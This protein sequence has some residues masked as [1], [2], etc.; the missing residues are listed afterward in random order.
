[1]LDQ[2]IDT[3]T[4]DSQIAN[5]EQSS[6]RQIFKA[7]SLFGG[8]QV[9]Q[10]LIGIVRTKFVA[11][12]LGTT[13]VG[14][15][16][17]FNAPLQLILSVTGL[18]IT[19]SAVRDISEAYSSSDLT[20]IGVTVTT[21]R[22]WSLFAGILGLVVTALM[23]PLLSEWTFGNRDYTW[24]FVWLSFTLLLQT[25]SNGQKS[26]LQA[27]RRLKDLARSGVW[28][29]LLGLLTSVPLFYLFGVKGIVPSLIITAVT[30][31]LLSWH[32]SRKVETQTVTMTFRETIESGKS[33][34]KLGLVITVTGVIGFLTVYILNTF[35]NRTGGVDQVGLYNAGWNVIGQS[36]GLVFAAMTTDYFPRLAA[37]N[38][39][40]SI[41]NKLVNHQ[42]EMVTLILTP[43]LVA[44]IVAMPLLIRILYTSSFLPVV[45]FASWLLLGILFKGFVWPVGFIFPAKG[46]LKTFG[47]IEISALLFNIFSN[48]LGYHFL[49]LNGLGISFIIN[50]TF[51]LIITFSFAYKKYGFKYNISTIKGLIIS[52]ILVSGA[53][54]F[55]FFLEGIWRYFVGSLF[56][57]ITIFYTYQEL[58]KRLGLK[59]LIVGVRAKFHRK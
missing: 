25:V 57:A 13:G 37:I 46:D 22:R 59:S 54:S 10:I 2:D 9:F 40:D 55:S 51:G 36:T 11:V 20:R 24:A 32:F 23:A 45:N 42:A 50:Y 35:I 15:M 33:M 28:G 49:G 47:I 34:V 7:T 44:L 38:K 27:T 1:M 58:N 19:F 52:L 12:L 18:G 16:G 26:L 21:L 30:S 41:V 5:P 17:L 53:F 56:F 4:S 48:V 14:I 3:N 6:Y 43:I 8:V 31:L 29:S 39:D